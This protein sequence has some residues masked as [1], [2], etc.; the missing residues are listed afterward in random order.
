MGEGTKGGWWRVVRVLGSMQG[1]ESRMDGWLRVG[2]EDSGGQAGNDP[3][4]DGI[5]IGQL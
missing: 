1:C 5:C 3:T 2:R 4:V